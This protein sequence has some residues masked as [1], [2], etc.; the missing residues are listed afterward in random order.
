MS[1]SRTETILAWGVVAAGLLLAFIVGLFTYM[2]VTATPL[3]PDPQKVPS[4][5]RAAPPPEWADAA[6]KA[7]QAVRAALIDQNLPGL[8]VAVG[9]GGGILWA[10]GF[11]YA[12]LERKIPVTPETKFRIAGVSIPLTSAAVGVL[13]DKHKLDLDEPIQ[14]YV[15][16]FPT[17][18]WPVTL[19]EL[20]ADVAGI[21]ND[22]GDEEPLMVRCDRTIDGLRR[23]A[24]AP[25]LFEPGTR[26]HESSYG[27]ILVS[28]AVEAAGDEPFS[29]FM[30]ARI[31]D[32]LG[33]SSTR[34]EAASEPIPD[35]ATFYYPRFAGD[36]RYGPDP[37]REGDQS[38]FAG[39]AGYLSTPTDLVRF[40]NAMM[41]GK[42]LQPSTLELLQTP[43]RLASG[44]QSEYGLGWKIETVPLAGKPVRAAGHG[45]KQDFIG[46]TASFITFPERALVVAVTSN[47]SFANTHDIGVA[48]ARAF[49]ES[50]GSR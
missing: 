23:F 47:I 44:Q 40:G 34:P 26:Y 19:R 49:A 13:L 24:D 31:F 30:R 5:M 28:A 17:K 14:A 9:A 20:M 3:H 1:R 33:M 38:C 43:Q 42:L 6:G 36:P 50:A 8:S 39:A 45:T 21:R 7:R 4:V 2:N 29:T 22:A 10:E 15:P 46:G 16:R 41:T 25:L 27:W 32:P 35:R 12:D 37:A 11:G 48:I 18:K